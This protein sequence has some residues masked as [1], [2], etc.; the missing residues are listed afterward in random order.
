MELAKKPLGFWLLTALVVGNMIGSGIFL[1]PANLIHFGKMGLLAW[2]VASL[3]AILLAFILSK[4]SRIITRDGG[5]FAYAHSGMGKFVGFQT[6]YN[7]WIAIWAANLGLLIAFVGYLEMFFPNGLRAGKEILIALSALWILTLINIWGIKKAAILQLITTI[8]KVTPIV[9]ISVFGGIWFFHQ[10]Y[11]VSSYLAA[12]PP[13][14]IGIL[15]D[16]V[17]ITLW[18]FIGLESAT[19]PYRFVENPERNIPR[20]TI[21]GTIIAAS[22]YIVGSLV[23]S[24]ILPPDALTK[25]AYPFVAAA[26]MMFGTWGKWGMIATAAISCFGCING[27]ILIQGQVSAAA[28]EANLFPEIF[29]IR[30]SKGVPAWGLAVTSLLTSVL[31][32]STMHKN[33]AEEFQLVLAM[34]S[35]A[36]LIPYLYSGAA[37]IIVSKNNSVHSPWLFIFGSL[38]SLY[39][40]WAIM[41]SNP[42]VIYYGAILLLTSIIIYA[43]GYGDNGEK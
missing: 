37:S 29:G 12:L 4:L 33:L 11:T 17:G 39:M 9:A 16:A 14:N 19:V 32:F 41:A 13:S 31:L 43:W 18:A 8:L 2:L 22:I 21:W 6:I 35:L 3:G 38:F 15:R 26:E 40:L 28:S 27:W 5:P 10:H 20:A 42:K 36:T 25:T 34:A 7:Y 1:L 24:G 30:N 23:I